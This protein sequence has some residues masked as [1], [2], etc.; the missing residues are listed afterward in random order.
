MLL[1][2]HPPQA[3][4]GENELTALEDLVKALTQALS[5][6]QMCI[7]LSHGAIE[8][9]EL[10]AEGWPETHRRVVQASGWLH[11]SPAY[12]LSSAGRRNLA[13]LS[14]APPRLA[15]GTPMRR[16]GIFGTHEDWSSREDTRVPFG[17]LPALGTS[18]ALF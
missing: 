3:D 17:C 10:S 1:R 13:R 15:R 14:S 2:R 7:D 18:H 5:Q 9:G 8:P 16:G 11:Q 12:Q 6:G 4:L